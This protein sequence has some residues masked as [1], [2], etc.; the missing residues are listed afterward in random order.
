[1]AWAV[2]FHSS[3]ALPYSTAFCPAVLTCGV[4]NI[5]TVLSFCKNSRRATSLMPGLEHLSQ[6]LERVWLFSL[7]KKKLQATRYLTVASKG[8][9]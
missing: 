7:E 5:R 8:V 3:P 2:V 9:L 6:T 4:P 1:M